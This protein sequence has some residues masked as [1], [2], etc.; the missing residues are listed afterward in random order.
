[1]PAEPPSYTRL[2]TNKNNLVKKHDYD[3][4]NY[5]NLKK[6]WDRG[7]KLFMVVS[8]L[9]HIKKK[10][11]GKREVKRNG[12]LDSKKER[13]QHNSNKRRKARLTSMI[14]NS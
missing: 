13:K 2:N 6:E 1:M 9:T 4:Y 7:K 5:T 14:C 3:I 8:H 12:N 11:E 10:K